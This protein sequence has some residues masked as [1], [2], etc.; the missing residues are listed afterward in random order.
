MKHGKI[1]LLIIQVVIVSGLLGSFAAGE[2]AKSSPCSAKVS[3]KQKVAR[4]LISFRGEVQFQSWA[5]ARE[6]SGV[7]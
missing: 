7:Q 4:A 2:S 1:G 6:A 5:C 3:L